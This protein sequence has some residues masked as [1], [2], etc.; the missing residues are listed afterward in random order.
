MTSIG[1]T[2][3]AQCTGLVSINIPDSVIS[4]GED[5]LLQCYSLTAVNVGG[6]NPNY[7]SS[8]GVMFDKDKTRL[9]IYP[10]AKSDSEYTVPNGVVSVD[11]YAFGWNTHLS[12]VTL[13]KDVS[14][15]GEYA[16]F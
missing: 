7:S 12:T 16:F 10:A 2:A 9:M 3:F 1:D 13:G 6:S 15:L 8:N 11:S 14:T 4:L 5:P